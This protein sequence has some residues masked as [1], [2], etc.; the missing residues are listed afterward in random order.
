MTYKDGGGVDSSE[1]GESGNTDDVIVEQRG[2]GLI[3]R[4]MVLKLEIPGID[5]GD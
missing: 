2:T 3:S 4:D 5:C 1:N